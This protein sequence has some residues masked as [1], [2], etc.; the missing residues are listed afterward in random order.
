MT[1]I[2]YA[3]SIPSKIFNPVVY[4]INVLIVQMKSAKISSC[5]HF[6]VM[7][8]INF[9]TFSTFTTLLYSGWLEYVF[10]YLLTTIILQTSLLKLCHPL[11]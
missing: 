5:P 8:Q 4:D 6:R 11:E 10:I 2:H 9:C 1:F 7:R 3:N